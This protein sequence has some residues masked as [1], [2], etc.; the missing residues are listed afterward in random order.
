MVRLGLE[1]V[2]YT[3]NGLH[4]KHEDTFCAEELRE[5]TDKRDLK[6][7]A[8]A[9]CLVAEKT[10]EDALKILG[11]KPNVGDRLKMKE[12]STLMTYYDGVEQKN[13]E[14]K[15]VALREQDM[16]LTEKNTP[17]KNTRSGQQTTRPNLP[18]S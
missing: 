5:R 6:I 9:A 8:K 12:L 7:K 3:R 15:V 4:L 14:T 17:K 2:T 13:Q 16:N 18:S 11:A 1:H 10:G